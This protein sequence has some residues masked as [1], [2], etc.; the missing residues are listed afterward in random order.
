[1]LR[2]GL[3][4][5]A[6]T[7]KRLML[8]MVLDGLN[9]EHRATAGES[10]SHKSLQGDAK[11]C[12]PTALATPGRWRDECTALTFS[13]NN[14]CKGLQQQAQIDEKPVPDSKAAFRTGLNYCLLSSRSMVRIHQGASSK[15]SQAKHSGDLP[16]DA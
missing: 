7:S 4:H 6:L 12:K 10:A 13:S 3:T 16:R 2:L 9:S 15:S 5:M 1:M 11:E 8:A 14:A